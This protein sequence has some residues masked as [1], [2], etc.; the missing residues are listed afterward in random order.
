MEFAREGVFTRF[1]RKLILGQNKAALLGYGRAEVF[2]IISQNKQS[3]I[4]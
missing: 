1:E 4:S 2:S 3:S